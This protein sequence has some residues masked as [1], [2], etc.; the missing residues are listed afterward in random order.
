MTDLN[1]GSASLMV[2]SIGFLVW[3]TNGTEP[4]S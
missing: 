2:A 4:K 3:G 1:L